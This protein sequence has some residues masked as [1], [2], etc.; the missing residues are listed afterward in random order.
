MWFYFCSFTLFVFVFDIQFE[1]EFG[2]SLYVQF[3]YNTLHGD[4]VFAKPWVL[5]LV[6]EDLYFKE[7]AQ[8]WN[9]LGLYKQYLCHKLA[10]YCL[11]DI[12]GRI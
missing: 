4:V 10:W 12:K 8:V 1:F 6:G 3:V 2:C 7:L 11:G 9:L 5:L